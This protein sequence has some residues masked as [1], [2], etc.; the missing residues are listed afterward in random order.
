M[1]L[2]TLHDYMLTVK[3]IVFSHPDPRLWVDEH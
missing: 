3:Q 2:Q 1:L